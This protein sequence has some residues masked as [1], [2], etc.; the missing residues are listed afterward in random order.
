[1][2]ASESFFYYIPFI[3][4]ATAAR[5]SALHARGGW[6]LQ[7]AIV[8]HQHG[9]RGGLSSPAVSSLGACTTPT[10]TS[11]RDVNG[12]SLRAGILQPLTVAVSGERAVTSPTLVSC[13]HSKGTDPPEPNGWFQG[14]LTV[15]PTNG[16]T[17]PLE[18][19]NICQ[20]SYRRAARPQLFSHVD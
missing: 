12:L 3:E 19:S 2:N 5:T 17:G 7:I 15:T 10:L 9:P 16:L 18:L 14:K 11:Y 8:A 1:M 4:L 13:G 20:W 6:Q